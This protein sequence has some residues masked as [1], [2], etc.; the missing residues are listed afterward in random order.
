[1]GIRECRV[2][3]G[4]GMEVGIEGRTRGAGVGGVMCRCEVEVGVWEVGGG[5]TEVGCWRGWYG[6]EGRWGVRLE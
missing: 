4:S 3:S 2:Q 5:L 6:C 1:M